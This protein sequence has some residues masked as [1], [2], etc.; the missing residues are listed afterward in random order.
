MQTLSAP[1]RYSVAPRAT[2][3]TERRSESPA[4]WRGQRSVDMPWT[5]RGL[6]GGG[7]SQR[8]DEPSLY[9]R[10]ERGQLVLS[11]ADTSR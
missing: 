6:G 9:V 8:S 2:A 11:F 3:A 1:P 10:D 4:D 7:A 5:E